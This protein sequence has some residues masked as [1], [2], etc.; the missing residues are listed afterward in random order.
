VPAISS[1]SQQISPEVQRVLEQFSSVFNEP[2]G[3]PPIKGHE[4]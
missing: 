4:H 2:K 3:L 1:V